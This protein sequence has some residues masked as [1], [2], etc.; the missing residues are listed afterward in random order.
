M[1]R[2]AMTAKKLSDAYLMVG[3]NDNA[4]HEMYGD[5]MDA[6]YYLIGEHVD[7]FDK[8]VTYVAVN[9]PILSDNRRVELLY[10]EFVKNHKAEQPKPNIIEQEEMRKMHRKNGGYMAPE[11]DWT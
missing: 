10:S 7:E 9:A 8:S 11:G 1:V 5:I 2:S 4:M 3:L 6:I